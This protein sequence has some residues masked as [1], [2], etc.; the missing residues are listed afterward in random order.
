[1]KVDYSKFLSDNE[2]E[3]RKIVDELS[4]SFEHVTVLGKDVRGKSISAGRTASAVSDYFLGGKGFVV[5]AYKDGGYVEYSFN[6]IEDN[7]ATTI[8]DAFNSLKTLCK[9]NDYEQYVTTCAEDFEGE[10]E[11]FKEVGRNLSTLDLKECVETL[12][13]Y[14]DEALAMDEHII[15]ARFSTTIV[16]VSAFF[17]SEKGIMR[18]AYGFSEGSV[19]VMANKDGE[20][21]MDHYGVSGLKGVEILDELHALTKTVVD[22]TLE[23][24]GT[25]RIEPGVYDVITRP[26]VTGLIAHEAFGH[27]VEMDMFVKN[28]ALAKDYIGKQIA[29]PIVNMR[30]GAAGIDHVS[31]Y[32][33]DDEGTKGTDTQ[34]IKDGILVAGISDLTS[35][36]RLGTV[37]T[38][39]G[40]R[41]STERKAY[42][43][44]T[45]TY[46]CAGNDKYEDMVKSIEYGFQLEG[47]QSGMEDPKHWG[48][49]CM[50]TKGREIKDGKFTGRIVSPVILTGY[51]PDLLKSISMVS[52][53]IEVDGNGYCGKGHK[54][55]V[56]TSNGGPYLKAKARLG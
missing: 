9:D 47:M 37:P 50:V 52:E 19:A 39:N 55:W 28:R 40:K 11:C 46:F 30:D 16:E 49:Q 29:S 21:K 34:I 32:F 13:S 54:E 4:K 18:Q 22:S 42:T 56:K 23:L 45:N 33:F 51:V 10:E 48:I 3:I 36:N 1:M 38:G 41:E 43:R 25:E 53:E 7:M 5:R 15:E 12:K 6:Q 24:F 2:A 44:M 31:S 20:N 17:M 8:K 26:D 27:G 14:S 35:A